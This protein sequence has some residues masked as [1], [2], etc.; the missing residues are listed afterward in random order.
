MA[1]YWGIAAHSA[2][3]VFLWYKYL[4][5]I[6]VFPT[7]RFMIVPFPDHCLFV[8]FYLLLNVIALVRFQRSIEINECTFKLSNEFDFLRFI[9]LWVANK[10]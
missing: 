7:P 4:S 5:V 2:Y 9:E 3:D 1:A 8:L 10:A 6:L